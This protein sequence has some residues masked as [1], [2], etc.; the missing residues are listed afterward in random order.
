ML[1]LA[2]PARRAKQREMPVAVNSWRVLLP[3]AATPCVSSD[4]RVRG[5]RPSLAHLA[6]LA[7]CSHSPIR[8]DEL[9]S[10]RPV[11]YH[12]NSSR[13]LLPPAGARPSRRDVEVTWRRKTQRSGLGAGCCVRRTERTSRR[14]AGCCRSRTERR[15]RRLRSVVQRLRSWL[16]PAQD[17]RSRGSAGCCRRTSPIGP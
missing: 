9:S 1:A 4:I 7:T 10:G 14:C 8:H 11:A 3:P 6:N 16:L 12:V 17:R 2:D 15:S 13:V 5:L